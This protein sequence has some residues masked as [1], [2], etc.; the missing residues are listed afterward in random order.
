[1]CRLYIPLKKLKQH[2][3]YVLY[4]RHILY[5]TNVMNMHLLKLL[6]FSIV[7][8]ISFIAC[9]PAKNKQI[10]HTSSHF[11]YAHN[12]RSNERGDTVIVYVTKGSIVDSI[13]YILC[14][15]TPALTNDMAKKIFYIQVPVTRVA[16][17]STTEIACIDQ[18]GQTQSIMA[19]CD[20]FRV[21][22][23]T[24]QHRY[25]NG[26]LLDLGSSMNENREKILIAKPDV[27]IKT[28][29]TLQEI[30]KDA[31]L[32][33]SGIPVV[34]INNWLETTAL[35]RTEWIKFIGLLYGKQTLA[36][37]VFASIEKRYH[38]LSAMV[39]HQTH[40][41]KVLAGDMI[42]DVWYLPGGNSYM[43]QFITDA[44]GEY[45]YANNTITGSSAVN[46]EQL[47]GYAKHAD[48]WVGGDCMT[49][50]ELFQKN[51]S[52]TYIPVCN[53]NRCFNYHNRR[54]PQGGNDYWESGTIR[55]DYILAD[56]IHIF[57][58]TVLPEH[59][60]VYFK[61]IE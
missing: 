44:G 54:T 24:I 45:V 51:E 53:K 59:E 14:D 28:L 32:I 56:L 31:V 25:K 12:I 50:K 16:A 42:K 1:M 3:N 20:V 33:Q 34:Y 29:F 39:K 41:P 48:V 37:S 21:S 49:K 52:Y 5:S 27:V 61:N 38:E 55:A 36:D 15:S 18:I 43:A 8:I 46:I 4:Y 30:Q 35:G 2:V 13:T 40:K 7:G 57:H 19:V 11:T 23:T 47:I 60:L 10:A 58:P 6:L 9:K 22:N 17:L 26:E